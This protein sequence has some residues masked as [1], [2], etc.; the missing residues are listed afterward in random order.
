MKGRRIAGIIIGSIGL[1][2]FIGGIASEDKDIA[3]LMVCLVLVGVGL[4]LI[5]LKP[6]K[7]A[8]PVQE[9]T[10]VKEEPKPTKRSPL[11][12]WELDGCIMRYSYNIKMD[13]D[14]SED[15]VYEIVTFDDNHVL[16]NG[17][18]LSSISNNTILEM[19]QKYKYFA[20]VASKTNVSI[21]FYK[22]KENTTQ[23]PISLRSSKKYED[24]L[25]CLSVG[26]KVTLEEDYD[27]E[28][29]AFILDES[30][31]ELQR[32][33]AWEFNFDGGQKYVGEVVSTDPYK[34]VFYK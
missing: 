12:P 30:G 9:T 2:A 23:V 22:D 3:T 8:E 17:F 28:D 32:I 29:K 6:K 33:D 26:D 19:L 11:V 20:Y 27:N 31:E 24:V 21:T 13:H 25:E 16:L 15:K 10:P 34:V 4:L 1:L 14:V 5:L 7:K 18:T